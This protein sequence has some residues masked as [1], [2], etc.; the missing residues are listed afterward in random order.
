MLVSLKWLNTYVN[1]PTNIDVDQFAETLTMA[2]A[3]VDAVI[4]IG[5]EWDPSLVITAEIVSIDKHPNADRLRLA[6]VNYGAEDNQQVVCGAPNLSIGQKVAFGRE[7]SELTNPQTGKKQKLKANKIRGITSAGMILSEAELGISD[8]HDGIIELAANTPIGLPLQDHLG[9]TIL[10]IHIWPNRPDMMSMIGIAREVSAILNNTIQHPLKYDLETSANN[11]QKIKVVIENED[12][13]SRYIATIIKNVSVGPSPEWLQ[14]RL[15]SIGQRPINNVVDI[16]NYVMFELGQPLHAFD[17]DKINGNITVRPAHQNE[18]LQTLDDLDRTLTPE[19]LVIADDSQPIALAG[20][21]GGKNTEVTESTT[22]ILLE[23][24]RFDPVSVRRTSNKLTLRSEASSRF[25]RGLSSHLAL[26]ATKRAIQLFVE[27]TGATPPDSYVDMHPA[28]NENHEIQLT[29]ARVDTLIGFHIST[30]EITSI[31]ENLGFAVKS[32]LINDTDELFIVRAPWWR[33]DITIPDDVIEEIVRLAG[34]DRLPES[35]ISGQIPTWEPNNKLVL[36]E[37]LRDSLVKMGW[38]EIITYSLTTEEVLEKILPP[39]ELASIDFFRLKNT[40]SSDREILRPTLRHSILETIERNIRLGASNIA[41]FEIASVYLSQKDDPLPDEKALA[42]G[43]ISGFEINRW[44]QPTTKPLD[45][46]DAK[47]TVENLLENLDIEANYEH[48]EIFGFVTGRTAKIVIN[49]TIIGFIGEVSS[50][51]LSQFGISQPTILFE[52]ELENL[53]NHLTL[54][55]EFLPISKF[56]S[57]QQDLSLL[58]PHSISVGQ[59]QTIF[60]NSRLVSS[61][62]PFDVYTGD[63]IEKE[64]RAIA[65]NINYQSMERTLSKEDVEKEQT[66]ILAQLKKLYDIRPRF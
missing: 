4:K 30:T 35:T 33:T 52:L 34:Y 63:G 59:V 54:Q 47:G 48:S 62:E 25:E 55:K 16:T 26:D 42:T 10:D 36:R 2:S 20:V 12:L 64:Y 3:E 7:G 46:F 41:I 22:N 6:T 23:A 28:P 61:A 58:V 5:K 19:M 29:R 45:F 37:E 8:S 39:D 18:P 38:Q 27:I 24:A 65:L 43:A 17:L 51:T 50:E 21:M 14:E 53:L 15:K 44:S 9:D 32:T 11:N 31:L 1:L 60:K 40:L 49:D 13:C 66:K 56:P 57:V